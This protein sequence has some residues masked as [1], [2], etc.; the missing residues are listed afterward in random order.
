MR[1]KLTVFLALL[2]LG[3]VPLL[4]LAS[5]NYWS[6]LRLAEATLQRNQEQDLEHFKSAIS[7]FLTANKTELTR[8]SRAKPLVQYLESLK[9]ATKDTADVASLPSTNSEIVP[10]ELQA[11]FS[12]V[13]NARTNVAS[14]SVFRNN[15]GPLFVAE[16]REHETYQPVDFR[17]TY[18]PENQ[19]KPDARVWSTSQPDI[20]STPV[21]TSSVGSYIHF[22][23]PV[24]KQDTTSLVGALVA[25]VRLDPVFFE[26]ARADKSLIPN[27]SHM[28]IVLDRSGKILYHTNE[29]A[30]EQPLQIAIPNF[31]SITSRMLSTEQG[32]T[33]FIA[34]NNGPEYLTNYARLPAL[35]VIVVRASDQEKALADAHLSGR[36]GLLIATI[37]GIA[38]GALL[39][40]YWNK[41]ARG[42]R[43]VSE[44]VE[45]IAKGKLDHQIDLR[46][47]DD[48]RPLADNLEVMKKQMRDQ[49]AREAETQQF[50]SFV[51]LSAI[52]TH[53]LKNAIGALSLTVSNMERH[54]ENA[55][56]RVDGHEDIARRNR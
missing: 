12:S 36:R 1:P 49:L 5:I 9:Q 38:T 32:R 25:E 11:F 39:Y 27:P 42:I 26:A 4:V 51:R 19:P 54:S 33:S 20:I 31:T 46:S 8:F 45:A 16:H 7:E 37:L 55:A 21:L 40:V 29:A 18:F 43:R 24:F 3:L 17:T 48:L 41:K 44:G 50:Q 56:F 30:R 52:L 35:D 13:F 47:R 6:A 23:V 2:G 28:F 10:S 53:D 34:G 14:I 15:D 22:T